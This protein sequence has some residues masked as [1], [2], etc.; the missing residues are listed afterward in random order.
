MANR[1]QIVY[2][3]DTY[4]YPR[5]IKF[6]VPQGTVLGPLLFILYINSIFDLP[7]SGQIFSYADDTAVFY[8]ATSWNFLKNKVEKDLKLFKNWFDSKLLTINILKTKYLPCALYATGLPKFDRL[9]IGNAQSIVTT[10]S[11]KYLGVIFYSHLR[12]DHHIKSVTNKL[13]C[14]LFRYKLLH[15]YLP[16]VQ[17]KSVY[18]ALVE[19]HLNYGIIAWGGALNTHMQKL[20]IIQKNV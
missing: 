1:Q 20:E 3:N 17:L 4:S 7:T 2:V 11:I 10:S 5:T 8:K 19:S 16:I 14:L 15:K 6:G 9:A 13:R 18:T 12:W